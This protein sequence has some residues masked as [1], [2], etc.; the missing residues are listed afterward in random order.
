MRSLITG[1]SGFAG[2]ALHAHLK[3]AGDDVIAWSRAENGPDIT[4]RD[5]VF[6][7]MADAEPDVVYHLAAQSHVP[8][9]WEDPI[10]TIRANVEGTQN[11]VDAAAAAN[12]PR[13]VVVTSAEVYGSV[14]PEQLPI[15]EDFPLRP[16]NPYAVSKVAADAVALGA[17][18]GT[19]LDVIRIR[20]FNHFGP[21]QSPSFVSA[22]FAQR[23]AVAAQTGKTSIEVGSLDVA[24]D[25]TDVRDVVRAYRLAGTDGEPGE[26]Y[27]VCSG[28][29][30]SIREIAE[31][32]VSRSGI[33]ISLDP[34]R[35]LQR[36]VDTPIVVGSAARINE[37]TG[38]EPEISFESSLD[39]IYTE[40][41]AR[42]SEQSL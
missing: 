4:Q 17:F 18:L 31:A 16:S 7:A 34:S 27:N 30:R 6:S 29:S 3:A 36:P 21:G 19:G 35:E 33:N 39:D 12:R 5:P 11:V 10:A 20:A 13:V 26:V 8:T 41:E 38:W 1:A 14:K 22:G 40:A 2:T 42:A 25:F 32:F 9:A 23:I 28:V 24:R 37:H 15:T